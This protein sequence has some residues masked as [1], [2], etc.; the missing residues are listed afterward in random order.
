M[1]E[2][3]K[4]L[5]EAAAVSREARPPS[6][7]P[8][9][10][11]GV[12]TFHDDHSD[13]C[14]DRGTD[15]KNQEKRNGDGRGGNKY[16]QGQGDERPRD[17]KQSPPMIAACKLQRCLLAQGRCVVQGLPRGLLPFL[18]KP[19]LVP[20]S[21]VPGAQPVQHS[22]TLVESAAMPSQAPGD[23][24]DSLQVKNRLPAVKGLVALLEKEEENSS[25]RWYLERDVRGSSAA[26]VLTSGTIAVWD[27]FLGQCTAL[28]PPNSGGSWSLARWSI[29][30]T[31]LLAG[32]EDGSV[33]LY[34]AV[35]GHAK[36]TVEALQ[37]ALREMEFCP[38]DSE[39]DVVTIHLGYFFCKR[40]RINGG[41]WSAKI[42]PLLEAIALHPLKERN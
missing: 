24:L 39:M 13:A 22:G 29:T 7:Q 37:S 15:D 31:C 6:S 18:T 11:K 3:S 34:R 20:K 16:H 30:D 25:Q 27:L 19:V 2:S 41:Y 8:Q 26:A 33:Y 36:L 17:M 40:A 32:Q 5:S 38:R 28:L 1:F 12:N 14:Q 21:V 23:M 4:F 35:E 10:P 42:S 9:F